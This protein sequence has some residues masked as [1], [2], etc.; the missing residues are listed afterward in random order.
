MRQ[1]GG[2]FF[3]LVIQSAHT[4]GFHLLQITPK[5]VFTRNFTYLNYA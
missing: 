4:K 1:G 3:V 2:F 5:T